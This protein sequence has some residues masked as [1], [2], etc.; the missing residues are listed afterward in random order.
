MK[1][2]I[3]LGLLAAGL[4]AFV[5]VDVVRGTL[6]RAR[7]EIRESLTSQIPL[8][9]QLAEAQAQIDAY[10]ESVIRGEV[11]AENLTDMIRDVEREVRVLDVHVE[12]E[13]VA[14]VAMR[15]GL[16]VV[17]T[18]TASTDEEREAVRRTRLFRA[19]AELLE[20]RRQDLDR[21]QR[22]QGSTIASLEEARQEQ[23][24]LAEEVY[25]LAAEIESLEA[26]TAAARTREAVGDAIVS[27]SGYAD[28]QQ[29]LKSVRNSIR[30]RNK[31]LEYYE[32]E[33]RPIR[34]TGALTV[35]LEDTPADARTAIDDVLAAF[36]QR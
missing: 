15:R 17:P 27:S 32:Y 14:L 31:L 30:E 28:A 26:R 33:R 4:V 35:R 20:R 22:E 13:R 24:R 36:P 1:K 16:E 23:A 6:G 5:G 25:V 21:L 7:D 34:A 18:S 9:T 11:A 2:L 29:R 12:R 8:R 10:A 19:Q 3:V